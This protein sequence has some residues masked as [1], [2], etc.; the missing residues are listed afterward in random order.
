MHACIW[1]KT[2]LLDVKNEPKNPVNPI[3]GASLLS[4]VQ[5]KEHRKMLVPDPDY[6][7]WGWYTDIEFNGRPYTLGA[8]TEEVDEQGRNIFCFQVKKHR[9]LKEI[10][11]RCERATGD[12]DPCYQ[13]FKEL[14]E[15]EPSFMEPEY[16]P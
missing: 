11:L 1:F 9:T 16:E 12:T 5:E 10:L 15:S 2:S 14:F 13:H 4:W 8:S 7:D 6:E 3:M